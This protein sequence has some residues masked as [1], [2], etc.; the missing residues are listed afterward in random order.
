[1]SAEHNQGGAML[2]YMV[3]FFA[4][5]RVAQIVSISILK[6][7]QNIAYERCTVWWSVLRSLHQGGWELL[8][9][10]M[11]IWYTSGNQV[12]HFSMFQMHQLVMAEHAPPT[13][14][15]YYW[16]LEP[17]CA[18][19]HSWWTLKQGVR[20]HQGG[21]APPWWPVRSI[22]CWWTGLLIYTAF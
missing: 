18:L 20:G 8:T 7:V 6:C 2:V 17:V 15:K 12:W 13:S 9:D 19:Q 4:R 22:E 10:T 11:N 1:M 14:I 5:H 3:S 21:A 16:L